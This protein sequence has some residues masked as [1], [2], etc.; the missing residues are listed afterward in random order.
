MTETRNGSIYKIICSKNNDAYVGSTFNALRTRMS[1]HKRTFENG[2]GIAIYSSFKRYGWASLKMILID[3]YEV[4]D[5]R[6]LEMYETL[7]VNK[8]KAVNKKVPFQPLR[9]EAQSQA[10]KLVR[11][12]KKE[13]P[14]RRAW[15]AER[16]RIIR[17]YR[18]PYKYPKGYAEVVK[19]EEEDPIIIKAI[20]EWQE[21]TL[22]EIIEHD[23][24]ILLSR[25]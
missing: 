14:V 13:Q 8:L 20:K 5:R 25:K 1:Q 9:K 3:T 16:K 22:K 2:E 17:E 12:K 4:V 19:M 11:T 6:H 24:K 10:A 7:W 21:P 15:Y 18:K 23:T